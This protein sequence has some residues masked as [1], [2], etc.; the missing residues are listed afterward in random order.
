MTIRPDLTGLPEG[1]QKL[2]VDIRRGLPVPMVNMF[3]WQDYDFTAVNGSLALT[4]AQRKMCGICGERFET[5]AFIGG[6]RSAET[7]AYSDPPMHEECAMAALTLCPHI[8]RRNMKRATDNHVKQDAITP[9]NMSLTKPDEWV[10]YVTAE[11]KI[12]IDG[13]GDERTAFYVPN[14]AIYTRRWTYDSEGKLV[15]VDAATGELMM[16]P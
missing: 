13:E 2:S 10:M 4:L 16:T 12:F 15:E 8:A 9:K 14:D 1:M 6:P 7:Q 3:E 5:A 11:Y